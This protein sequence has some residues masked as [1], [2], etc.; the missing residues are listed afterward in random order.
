MPLT[1]G[2]G[3]IGSLHIQGSVT[4]WITTSPMGSTNFVAIIKRFF[5]ELSE[6]TIA[7]PSGQGRAYINQ[8]LTIYSYVAGS[9]WNPLIGNT[10][11]PA[12]ILVGNQSIF[13]LNIKNFLLG[14]F[15]LPVITNPP[16]SG[17]IY[18]NTNS[19]DI[20][21]DLPVYAT[22]SGTAG[23]VTLA[24]GSSSTP[25][26]I[27]NQYVNG[28]TSSTSVDIIKLKVPAGWYYEFS[29]SGVTFGTASVFAD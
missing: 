27:G 18:Q 12:D 16:V 4:S 11:Y 26:S 3:A 23:Y 25:T 14:Q 17:T 28:A 24:K 8:S 6:P 21:I 20:E 9:T 29:T 1:G 2:I 10:T 7:I 5:S 19:Y 13:N 22:T 15:P